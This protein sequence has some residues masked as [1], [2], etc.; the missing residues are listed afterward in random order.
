MMTYNITEVNPQSSCI[1]STSIFRDYFRITYMP[2]TGYCSAIQI[3]SHLHYQ[4]VYK[5]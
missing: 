1:V 4:H 5:A 3:I 2:I